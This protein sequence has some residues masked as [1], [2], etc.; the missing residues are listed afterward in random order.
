MIERTVL[1]SAINKCYSRRYVTHA[2]ALN[3]IWISLRMH[4][5]YEEYISFDST[6]NGITANGENVKLK[7]D[8]KVE[9]FIRPL[10]L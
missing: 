10:D 5:F 3:T 9:T 6:D 2:P 4:K 8:V 1:R 7:F